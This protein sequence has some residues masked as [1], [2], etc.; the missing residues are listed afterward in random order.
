M[1]ESPPGVTGRLL[2]WT[3]NRQLAWY[4]LFYTVQCIMDVVFVAMRQ[5]ISRI[6]SI[7]YVSRIFLVK[8]RSKDGGGVPSSQQRKRNLSVRGYIII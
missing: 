3:G 8:L 6:L 5:Y 4:A 7:L 1:L 2:T